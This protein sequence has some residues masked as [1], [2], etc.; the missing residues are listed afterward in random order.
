MLDRWM[1]LDEILPDY[2]VA[3]RH[4]V[5]VRARPER[6]Y[7]AV[8]QVDFAR[9]P[10]PRLLFA[11]RQLPQLLSGRRMPTTLTL[12][13]LI[14]SGFVLL[15]EEPGREIVVGVVGRF[16]TLKG[17]R[18]AVAAERFGAFA[19]PGTAKAAMSFRVDDLGDGRSLVSTETRVLCADDAARRSFRRY[20]RLVRP[21]SALIRRFALGA[22]RREAEA[23]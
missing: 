19:E 13:D 21:G 1:L 2:D 7:A 11:I 8:H 5:V 16:W 22:I 14:R 4:S 15:G 6:A 10:V 9:S 3:D 23:R 20:W 18:R 17:D 12:G